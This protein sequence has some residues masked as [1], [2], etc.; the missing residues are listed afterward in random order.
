MFLLLYRLTDEDKYLHRAQ[1]FGSFLF[2]QTFQNEARTPDTPYSLY[3]GWAGTA[4][5][6]ADLIQPKQSEF[7]FSDVFS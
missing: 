6:L 2:T 3:E 4:C 7:P 1:Q 5:F